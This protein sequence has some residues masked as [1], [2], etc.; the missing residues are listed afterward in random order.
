M[1]NNNRKEILKNAAAN[2]RDNLRKSLQHR[3]EAARA[4]GDDQLLKNLEAEAAYL[5]MN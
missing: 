3:M 1:M 2:H 5:K 4:T